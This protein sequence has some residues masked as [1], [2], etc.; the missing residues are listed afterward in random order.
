MHLDKKIGLQV[1]Y[2][3]RTLLKI[4]SRHTRLYNNVCDVI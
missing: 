4:R 1:Q 3:A 2:D